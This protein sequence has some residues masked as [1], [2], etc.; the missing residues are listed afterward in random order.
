MLL[1]CRLVL[2]LLLLLLALCFCCGSSR[3][4]RVLYRGQRC[5]GTVCLKRRR[6]DE[7]GLCRL[8]FLFFVARSPV[9]PRTV[10]TRTAV[11]CCPMRKVHSMCVAGDLL[12]SMVC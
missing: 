2:L 12:A 8:F 4:C 3:R 11:N 5:G 10:L 1:D 6:C 9:G 7:S